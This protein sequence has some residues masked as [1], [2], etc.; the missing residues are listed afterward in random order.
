MK[1]WA[2]FYDF[3]N[4]DVPGVLSFAAERELRRAA[5][6]FFEKTK[7]WKF[8]LDP[9][10]LHPKVSQ[11]DIDVPPGATIVKILSATNDAGNEIDLEPRGGSGIVFLNQL[12]FTTAPHTVTGRQRV[13]FTAVLAPNHAA[14]GID[15]ALF[16]Q[17][18]EDIAHGAKAR[19]FAQRQKP[20]TDLQAAADERALFDSAIWREQVRAAKGF[21]GASLRTRPSFL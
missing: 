20:Y 2:Q 10:Y 13:N 12:Q 11:Y 14:K 9:I 4:A 19:L 8:D 17:Y 16:E 1:T 15:D 21:S 6:E 3:C 18:A 5:Q 7:V